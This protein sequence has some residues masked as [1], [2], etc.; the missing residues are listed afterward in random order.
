[1]MTPTTKRLTT[2]GAAATGGTGILSRTR[3]CIKNLPPKTTE[4]DLKEF[5]LEGNK[6]NKN[7]IPLQITDCKI[8]KNEKGKSRKVAFV[9]FRN[10]EQATHVIQTFHRTF[11][12]MTRIT[13]EAAMAKKEADDPQNEQEGNSN[14]NIDSKNKKLK[15]G[16]SNKNDKENVGSTKST[17]D[18]KTDQKVEEFLSLMGA[19]RKKSKFWSNDDTGE[20]NVVATSDTGHPAK[21]EDIS[22][23]SSDGDD[24]DDVNEQRISAKTVFVDKADKHA[25]SDLDF[26][27]SKQKKIDDLEDDDEEEEEKIQDDNESESN[28]DESSSSSSSSDS[29]DDDEMDDD[30]DRKN[31]DNNYNDNRPKEMKGNRGENEDDGD[32]DDM[33]VSGT[34]ATDT[35]LFVRNLPFETTEEELEEYFSPF[36]KLVECHIPVDDQK[37]NKGYAFI[38]FESAMDALEAR[39]QLDK[40]DFQGRLLHILKARPPPSSTVSESNKDTSNLTWKQK[41]ELARKEQE[42]KAAGKAAEGWSASFVRGDAVVDN[43]A[44]K[45]GLRKGDLLGV[46]DDLSSGDAAVR[47]ALGETQ[48]IEENREYFR[49][50]GIDMDVLVSAHSIGKEESAKRSKSAILVKNLPFDT[51]LEELTKLFHTGD[52]KVKILL[53]P[54]RTIALVEYG[55]PADAK[56]AFRNLAYRRFKHVPLYLEWAPL[57]AR[58]GMEG[59]STTQIADSEKSALTRIDVEQDED[60]NETTNGEGSTTLYIKNLNFGTT[61]ETLQRLFGNE[62]GSQVLS[63]RIPRKVAPT[64]NGTHDENRSLSM[65]YGFVELSSLEVAKKVMKLFQGKLVDGHP[66]EL[67]VSSKISSQRSVKTSMISASGG[68]KNPTKIMVRNVPFQATRQELLKLFGS[69]GQLRKVRLPKK[70]DGSHRGFAFVEFLTGKEAIAAMTALSQ[71]HLYGRHLVL[72]WASDEDENVDRLRDKAKRDAAGM[73]GQPQSKK[74]RFD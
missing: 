29:D 68:K 30:G 47:L 48:I 40:V 34:V 20:N 60:E 42:T 35:R 74:I 8:L 12:N 36:G 3:V 64:K 58:M 66:L 46:K 24:P 11:L 49:S 6:N 9:G 70:F 73:T 71:T 55:H 28:N 21:E 31:I 10:P 32:S 25:L 52:D 39:S 63:V 23:S 61:E 33:D 59:S 15:N 41:Q 27:K 67:A 50:H 2:A 13:V 37:R 45:L 4:H 22:D 72:E 54:S 43:L 62:V 19:T 44:E 38:T 56:K 18:L 26:L 5:L 53:P 16:Y 7:N 1:M 69:F 17:S 57:Q 65:G 14:S 51:K